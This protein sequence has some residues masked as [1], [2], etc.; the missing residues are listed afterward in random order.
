[1]KGT[2]EG[3]P[4]SWRAE[5]SPLDKAH[6]NHQDAEQEVTDAV[7]GPRA[8][9]PGKAEVFLCLFFAANNVMESFPEEATNIL[10]P[11]E[12]G[13]GLGQQWGNGEH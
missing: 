6:P 8:G 12:M 5:R 9:E 11:Q 2:G 10:P 1:M 3:G 7:R 13:W 4:P